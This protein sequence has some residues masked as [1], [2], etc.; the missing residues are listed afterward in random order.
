MT[1]PLAGKHAVV[2]GGGTGIGAAVAD[3][4]SA[5]GARVTLMARNRARL[6][7]KAA[8]LGDAQAVAV[9]ITDMDAVQAAFAEAE[10]AFGPVD[11]LVNNAGLA[12]AVPFH[13]MTLDDWNK[14]IA[15]NLHGTFHC[16]RAVA[17]G[18]RARKSGRIIN[19]ASTAGLAG[20][21]Y[22]SAYVAA[23][24][25]VMGLTRALA[26]ELA[27]HGVTVNAVC[28]GYTETEIVRSAIDNIMAKTGRTEAEARA[29]LTARNPQGKMVQPTEV[30]SAVAWLAL[31]EQAAMTGQAIAVAGGEIM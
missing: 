31:P 19:V 1:K 14:T 7:D 18:M 2:T 15:V 24:H 11:I 8:A 21:A 29:E 3:R 17:E 6:L 9:D 22:V 12:E 20:Y 13:K 10:Q 4:L 28:P 23:K 16:V 5:L 25:G 26:L 27:K 30:A